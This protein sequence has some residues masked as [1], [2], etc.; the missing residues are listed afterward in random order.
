VAT[1]PTTIGRYQV[2]SRLGTGGMGTVFLARDPELDRQLAIKL[3]KDDLTDDP[4]LR[5]R[6]AREARS[7]ARLR[8]PNIITVFDIGD[9][10]GR[11]FIAMEYIPGE[12]LA[13]VIR[14]RTVVDLGRALGWME[15]L[16][17][18]LAHAHKSGIVHRDIKPGNLMVDPEGTLKI[19]DFGIARLG[20]SQLTRDG[21]LVGTA[22]Y[23]APEQLLGAGTD[24]RADIFAVGAVCYELLTLQ[25]A[26]PGTIADGL[27][28]RICHEPPPPMERFRP[29]LD[30]AVVEIVNRALEKDPAWR[31]QD[32]TMMAQHL[33]RVRSGLVSSVV[34]EPI[35]EPALPTF[36]PTMTPSPSSVPRPVVTP[37][38]SD[39]RPRPAPSAYV[40]PPA[41]PAPAPTPVSAARSAYDVGNRPSGG[42]AVPGSGA[43]PISAAHESASQRKRRADMFLDAAEMAIGQRDFGKAAE[44]LDDAARFD[45]ASPALASMRAQAAQGAA[46][47]QAA[48]VRREEIAGLMAKARARFDEH[49]YDEARGLARRLLALEPENWEGQSLLG[50]I[51]KAEL[52]ARQAALREAEQAAQV[53]ASRRTTLWVVV[54]IVVVAA[55]VAGLYFASR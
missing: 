33:A 47:E 34:T 30:R 14:R 11:P 15:S 6:F 36:A 3:V 50:R 12:S 13:D 2:V 26:F 35:E 16:C 19:V 28:T 46:H 7:A 42:L 20:D 37:P 21:M 22:N 44:L 40:A 43:T 25:R 32:L 41:T 29:E 31:Y 1:Q 55:I 10:D 4:E 48:A 24:F 8:H 45:P 27:F 53:L 52:M 39:Q 49:S 18:G 5:E 17:A 23:M 51:E 54:A 9:V 38:A